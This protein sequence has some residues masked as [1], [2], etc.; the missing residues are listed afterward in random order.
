MTFRQLIIIMELATNQIKNSLQIY[1]RLLKAARPYWL[2]LIAGFI[3]TLLASAADAGLSWLVKPVVDQGLVARESIF[4]SWLPIIV[5]LAFV[6]RGAAYFASNYFIPRV[7][8]SVIMDFRQKIFSHLLH[9]PASFYDRESSG[10]LLS[11][12]IYNAEQLAGAATDSVLTILQ[13]G[14]SSIGLVVVMFFISWQLTLLFMVTAPPMVLVVR[15]ATKRLR[16]LSNTVQKSVGNVAHIAEEAIE[17]YRVVRTFGGENYERD[18]FNKA[19]R[20]NRHCEMK[21]I[22]TNSISTSIVQIIASLPMALIL[23]IATLPSLKLSVGSFGAIIVAMVRLLTPIRRLTRVN[24]DIQK[25]IA[26]ANSIFAVLEEPLEK[27]HGTKHLTRIKGHIEYKNVV[28]RYPSSHKNVLREVSFKMNPGQ[29][30]A[31]VGRSG[32]G[33]STLVSLLPRFH[34]VV[35]GEILIDGTNINKYKL[36]DLRHQFALV[37]QHVVLFNDTIARNVAYGRFDVTKTELQRVFDA[38]YLTDFINQLP[39]GA[40]TLIGENGVLLSGGQRQ[41]IAIA[42]AL[43]KNAPILILDEATSSLDTESEHYIQTA[44]DDLMRRHTTLVIAHRLST[45]EQA[46]KIM[47]MEQGKII[48]SGTH[49]EL[50]AQGGQYARLYKMQFKKAQH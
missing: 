16:M 12:I 27:D 32:S 25:G 23:Y 8:R 22:V 38:A 31:L 9:L 4:V 20:F 46:D 28:F 11:L 35:D 17:G 37:S 15:Y 6:V 42:R 30:V 14:L 34:D 41:R 29:T 39:E 2:T 48:E 45:V 13:E 49:A 33:K 18:K 19:S 10:K 43:L 3:G 36:R 24:T 26:A 5:I 1:L 21:V 44:L 7:G 47:V 50:L 40:N